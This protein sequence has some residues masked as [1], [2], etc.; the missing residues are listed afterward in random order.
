MP[1]T[2]SAQPD[3][4]QRLDRAEK[5]P[6]PRHEYLR[7]FAWQ[8]V[9]RLLVRPSPPRAYGWRNFWLRL[10]GATIGANSGVRPSVRVMHPWLLT[11]DHHAILGDHVNVYN[12][13]P[14]T[15]GAH[16]VVSQHAHLCGGTHDHHLPDRP[17]VRSPIAIG[18][19][20]WVCADAFVGPGVTVGD[21]SIVGARAV[22]VRDVPAHTVV[23]GNPAKVVKHREVAD[24][25]D[26]P[27]DIEGGPSC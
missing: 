22:V 9:W 16:T 24:P 27:N 1:D 6:Y 15:V 11:L 19:G 14:L 12:L 18:S 5:W 4:A 23:A 17:L 2:P 13:G 7:R 3:H 20:V 21:H 8:C 10:F 26:T 25:Q